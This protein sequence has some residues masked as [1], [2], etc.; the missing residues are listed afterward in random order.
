MCP[1]NSLSIPFSSIG[2][3]I[4]NPIKIQ[5]I[6]LRS[7]DEFSHDF[8]SKIGFR[9]FS[10]RHRFE[11]CFSRFSVFQPQQNY[12]ALIFFSLRTISHRPINRWSIPIRFL[13]SARM[14]HSLIEFCH[15]WIHSK[16]LL[17]AG[18]GFVMSLG[19]SGLGITILFFQHLNLLSRYK[20]LVQQYRELAAFASFCNWAW[21][22]PLHFLL[23]WS[24]FSRQGHLWKYK[25]SQSSYSRWFGWSGSAVA[26]TQSSRSCQ[27]LS[28]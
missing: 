21:A 9:F 19:S 28:P 7:T 8:P 26:I 6:V 25:G 27:L 10:S 4:G 17:T 1:Q 24:R 5:G 13:S 11:S 16:L 20:T 15:N 18:H 12:P 2:S 3:W 23:I 22:L 14:L